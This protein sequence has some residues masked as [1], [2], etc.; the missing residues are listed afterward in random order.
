[1]GTSISRERHG[2][3]M[4]HH[5]EERIL[6]KMTSQKNFHEACNVFLIVVM[7]SSFFN[8]ETFKKKQDKSII[9][10]MQKKTPC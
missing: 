3:S 4:A 7:R 10:M 2:K 9:R 8:D 6:T 1:M 5:P